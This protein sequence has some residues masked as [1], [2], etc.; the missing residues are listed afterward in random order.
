MQLSLGVSWGFGCSVG[1]LGMMSCW[2]GQMCS[3]VLWYFLSWALV[4][5]LCG[6]EALLV[7]VPGAYELWSTGDRKSASCL[8]LS[9]DSDFALCDLSKCFFWDCFLDIW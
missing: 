3:L 9:S 6:V 1:F 4:V 5:W 8:K 7:M 2:I